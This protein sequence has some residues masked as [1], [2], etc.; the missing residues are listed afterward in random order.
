MYPGAYMYPG[1]REVHRAGFPLVSKVQV[2]EDEVVKINEKT[3]VNM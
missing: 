2:K 1:A 3:V